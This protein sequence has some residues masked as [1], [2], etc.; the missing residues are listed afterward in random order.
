MKRAGI[1]LLALV[2]L[3]VALAGSAQAAQPAKFKA[4]DQSRAEVAR[5]W[6]A[7]RMRAA[8]PLDIVDG[9]KQK[10]MDIPFTRYEPGT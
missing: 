9:A 5:Y 4:V 10:R 3:V 6:T 8:I 2:A 7:D 1:L